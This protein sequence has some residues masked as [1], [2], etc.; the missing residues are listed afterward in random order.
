ML[1]ERDGS[2]YTEVKTDQTHIIKGQTEHKNDV[3]VMTHLY[4]LN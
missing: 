1:R 3:F 4:R 2:R